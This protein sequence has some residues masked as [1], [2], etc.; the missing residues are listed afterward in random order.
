MSHDRIILLSYDDVTPYNVISFRRAA[1]ARNI[2][3]QEWIPHRISVWC[4]DGHVEPLYENAPQDPGVIIHRT[5]SRLQGI[6]VPALRLWENSG[7]RILNELSASALT[8]DK[9]ATALKLT[10]AGLPVVPSLAFFPWEEIV[11]SRLPPGGTVLKPA[12][13]LQGR[14]VAFFI[15][16]IDAND[17]GVLAPESGI[18]SVAKRLFNELVHKDLIAPLE[19]DDLCEG[20]RLAIRSVVEGL[21]LSWRD[22]RRAR[23]EMRYS[24]DSLRRSPTTTV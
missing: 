20:D 9:L 22:L 10:E 1:A 7:S 17:S 21:I 14:D 24:E 13:G 11:F 19:W 12:H 15:G 8:R 6:V 5:I 4:G 3:L 2:K 16:V 23:S 18:D